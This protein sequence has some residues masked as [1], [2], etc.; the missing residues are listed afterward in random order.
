MRRGV[1]FASCVLVALAVTVTAASTAFGATIAGTVKGPDGAPFMGAF[2]I[3]ENTQNKMTVNVLSDKQ[4]RYHIANLPA[5]TYTVR[6]RAIG[7]QTDPRN[8]VQLTATRTRRLISPCKTATVRWS[9]LSTYQGRMLLPKTKAHDLTKGYADTFFTS[10][11][12]SC[13]SFQT[14]MATATRDEDG[15]RDRVKYMRD[16]IMAGEG[17]GR[18]SDEK[19]RGHRVVPHHGVRSRLAEDQVSR[20]HAGIQGHRASVQREGHEH[21]VRGIRLRGYQGPGAVERRRGQERDDVDSLLR[22]RQRGGEAGSQNRRA[23]P[24]RAAVHQD[25]RHSLGRSGS[26]RHRVVHRSR[27]GQDRPSQSRDQGDHRIP[28]RLARGP[29]HRQAHDSRRRSRQRVD[30]QRPDLAASIR[31]PRSSRTTAIRAPTATPWG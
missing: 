4:G 9:D 30:E 12:I 14:R 19:A 26:R 15:W 16:V 17:E 6:I 13:H 24:V 25:G 7:Y 18:M 2:V 31:K 29:A 1:E 3:A 23:D 28:G 10:C 27:H 21:R 11:M 20:G 8:G 22:A 5:A